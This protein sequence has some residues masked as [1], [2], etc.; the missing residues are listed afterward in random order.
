MIHSV[1]FGKFHRPSNCGIHGFGIEHSLQH[2]IFG[3][4]VKNFAPLYTEHNASNYR[5]LH[6]LAECRRLYGGRG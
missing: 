4:A 3:L 5:D 2:L 6:E 1:S